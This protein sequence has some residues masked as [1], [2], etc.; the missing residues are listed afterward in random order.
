[1]GVQGGVPD[2]RFDPISTRFSSSPKWLPRESIFQD[3]LH[4]HVDLR[5]QVEL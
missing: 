4:Q 1:M 3:A 2:I 5:R